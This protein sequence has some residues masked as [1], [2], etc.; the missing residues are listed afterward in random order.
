MEV[1]AVTEAKVFRRTNTVKAGTHIISFVSIS[2]R[3]GKRYI[4]LV[5]NRYGNTVRIGLNRIDIPA[6]V[7]NVIDEKKGS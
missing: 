5:E 7:Q 4:G 3:G 6:E 1:I 2:Y